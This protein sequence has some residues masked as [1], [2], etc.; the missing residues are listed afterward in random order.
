MTEFI[1]AC[2]TNDVSEGEPLLHE[3]PDGRRVAIF[4]LDDEIYAIDDKCTHG[5]ASLSDGWQDGGVIECP[6]HGGSFDIRTGEAVSFPCVD[7]VASYA[8]R[9][10]GDSVMIAVG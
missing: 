5:N 8:V 4:K 1:R 2:G 3:M 9:L 7:P 10:D 6:F